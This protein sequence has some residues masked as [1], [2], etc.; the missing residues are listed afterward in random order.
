M[1]FRLFFLFFPVILYAGRYYKKPLMNEIMQIHS[2]RQGRGMLVEL[3]NRVRRKNLDFYQGMVY[4]QM[5]LQSFEPFASN[6]VVSLRR[7]VTNVTNGIRLAWLGSALGLEGAAFY[8]SGED[9]LSALRVEEGGILLDRAVT[10][11]PT[12][13]YIRFLRLESGIFTGRFSIY[14]RYRIIE[15]DIV[16]LLWKRDRMTLEEQAR[17]YELA[18][19]LSHLVGR[20][21]RKV[22]DYLDRAIDTAPDSVSAARAMRYLDQLENQ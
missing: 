11:N 6:A 12:D 19:E 8:H 7:S 4:H 14:K 15:N 17:V 22:L 2:L 13:I 3:S 9:R 10:L 16:F 18:G 1:K 21:K 5:A 20:P